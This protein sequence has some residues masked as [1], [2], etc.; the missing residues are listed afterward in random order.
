MNRL[1]QIV[2]GGIEF[3]RNFYQSLSLRQKFTI[4]IGM[5]TLIIIISLSLAV[6][7]AE[8]YVLRERVEEICRVSVQNLSSVAKDNLLT[9][10]YVP[11]Q[12]VI[13]N[14]KKLRLEGFEYA[15]VMDRNG[16]MIAHSDP[17][18][19]METDNRYR[20]FFQPEEKLL[21]NS[22]ENRSE[23][24]QILTQTTHTSADAEQIIPIGIAGVAFSHSIVQTAISQAKNLIFFIS[25][26]IILIAIILVHVVSRQLSRNIVALSE[27]VREI[28]KGNLNVTIQPGSKDEIGLLAR[29]FNRMVKSLRENIQMQKFISR[30]TVDMIQSQE[31]ARGLEKG[32]IQKKEIAVL[33]TDVRGFTKLSE[34]LDPEQL[35]EIVNVYLNM[36]SKCIERYGGVVDKFAGDEL[37]A[38]F[39]NEGASDSALKAAIAIQ[40]EIIR[41]N[42]IRR[43][44]NQEYVTIG[45]GINYGY[46]MI[47]S[48]G[49]SSRMDYTAI[50]DVVNLASK[51]CNFAR[52]GHIIITKNVLKNLNGAFSVIKMESVLLS[53]RRRP[54]QIY[55]VVYN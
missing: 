51:L 46:A 29:E 8:K 32:A 9:D 55:R 38:I 30:L 44:N 18:K 43:T 10:R 53:G 1:F 48:M 52:A 25:F 36:Q 39:Q 5:I 27:G 42:K 26:G 45:I 15:F 7:E 24:L 11:I 2:Q 19:V 17:K 13:N 34:K 4:L 6:L 21:V 12:D 16:R 41:I 40:K 35:V 31:G 37:M 22:Q 20:S 14:M 28:A 54:I 49:A 23:Y 50:G 3:L 47:G 33:F